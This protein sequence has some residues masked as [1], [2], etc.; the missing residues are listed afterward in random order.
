MYYRVVQEIRGREVRL[1]EPIANID[2]ESGFLSRART[3]SA[4]S[5]GGRSTEEGR[6]IVA[7]RVSGD[8]SFLAE[9]TTWVAHFVKA[10]L[11][12]FK[13]FAAPYQPF[14]PERPEAGGSTTVKLEDPDGAL[15][16]PQTLLVP[17]AGRQWGLDPFLD[18][19]GQPLLPRTLQTK[20]PERISAG[21]V[22]AVVSSGQLAWG[23]VEHVE[24]RE[25]EGFALLTVD[26]WRHR[27]GGR[28]YLSETRLM[29]PFSR[30]ARLL[31]WRENQ[32]PVRGSQLALGDADA[33]SLLASGRRL[34]LETGEPGGGQLVRV[35]SVSGRTLRVSPEI[36]AEAGLTVS[37]TLVRGNVALAGHGESKP[38][39]I[40][41][42]GDATRGGQS[43]VLRE[44]DVSHPRDASGAAGVRA[45]V[46]VAVEGRVWEQVD[47]L[48]GS[49]PADAR[50]E[51][52]L[53][54]EGHLR[55]TFGDGSRG[56]R[57]PSGENNVRVRYRV[58]TGSCGNLE[59]GSLTSPVRPHA[60]VEGILQPLPA[61]GGNGAEGT[62]SLRSRAPR[63]VLT[64]QRA[65]SLADFAHLASAYSGIWQAEASPLPPSGRSE[66]VRVVVVP[67]EGLPLGE[68]GKD[69]R[70]FLQLRA[71]PGTVVVLEEHEPV[72]CRMEI[73]LRIRTSE[74]DPQAVRQEARLRLLETFSLRRRRIGQDLYL[75]E[76]YQAAES[77][78]GVRNS[79]CALD[80]AQPAAQKSL[81]SAVP[82]SGRGYRV[83]RPER[84]AVLYLSGD[85]NGLVLSHE[86]LE[87]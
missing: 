39:R 2:F 31:G 85:G 34:I 49:G 41:G 67:A 71:Q 35:R 42:S 63:T 5:Q 87:L 3:V 44:R 45:A 28:M 18:P 32:S 53:T 1:H 57:L 46:E 56:R 76:I 52:A 20:I 50:Y 8:L 21:A 23:A 51:V 16:N 26:R 22:V 65:V 62:R 58:G 78:P 75:S 7:V 15:R 48:R 6:S 77:V 84:N 79:H 66:R 40:L 27:G 61:T 80:L 55:I 83:L 36:R 70:E 82:A 43:F 68:L 37:N 11:R 38:Q 17:P 60:L 9:P 73:V 69:L 14:D 54:E 30:G 24:V 10:R 4:L 13:V 74:I 64:L 81:R 19:K 33:A 47:S 72:L 25:G 59:P 29:G 12:H 86:E